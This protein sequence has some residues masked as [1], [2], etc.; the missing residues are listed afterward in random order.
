MHSVDTGLWS[1]LPNLTFAPMYVAW[2]ITPDYLAD[3]AGY[4]VLSDL[5][6][7]D[8]KSL[9]GDG[10][11]QRCKMCCQF[12]WAHEIPSCLLSY[13]DLRIVFPLYPSLLELLSRHM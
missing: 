8:W 2:A 11:E 7:V 12:I 13:S 10:C 5:F 1:N 3:T 6:Q 9:Q 4:T